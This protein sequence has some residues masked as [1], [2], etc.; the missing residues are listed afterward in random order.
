MNTP[1]IPLL[2]IALSGTA[3]RSRTTTRPR[4]LDTVEHIFVFLRKLQKFWPP[5]DGWS[6]L[7]PGMLENEQSKH[8][9]CRYGQAH[10]N[11][12]G[13]YRTQDK[14]RPNMGVFRFPLVLYCA[15]LVFYVDNPKLPAGRRR[16]TLQPTPGP[17]YALPQS[18]PTP[19][20]T[21]Q[22]ESF[23]GAPTFVQGIPVYPQQLCHPALFSRG[24]ALCLSCLRRLCLRLCLFLIFNCLLRGK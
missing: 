8:R 5:R 16:Y 23:G 9:G 14:P 17:R 21:N 13:C 10:P 1:C 20:R 7:F 15:F 11:L 19:L 24:G 22:P 3:S 12:R 6:R 18:H 4:I 2:I